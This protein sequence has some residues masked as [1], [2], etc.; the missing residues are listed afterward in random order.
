MSVYSPQS[1]I[2]EACCSSD[3]QLPGLPSMMSATAAGSHFLLPDGSSACEHSRA[4][5]SRCSGTEQSR[6]ERWPVPPI[7]CLTRFIV[8]MKGNQKTVAQIH[9]SVEINRQS[10]Q[11]V[12]SVF[13]K[14]SIPDRHEIIRPDVDDEMISCEMLEGKSVILPNE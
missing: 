1:S 9:P 14:P 5:Q 3:V 10:Y 13:R 2:R 7:H 11:M 4:Q 8:S 6:A 12:L